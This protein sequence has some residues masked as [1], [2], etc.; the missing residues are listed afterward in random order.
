MAAISNGRND[1]GM[2]RTAALGIAIIGREGATLG[3]L[4]APDHVV[5]DPH[6][7]LDLLVHSQRLVAG[8]RP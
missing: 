4:A 2:I 8:L 1:V 7:A 5:A 3:L 6:A